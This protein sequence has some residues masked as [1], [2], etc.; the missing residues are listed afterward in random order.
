MMCRE[1]DNNALPDLVLLIHS[2][3]I[4]I[5]DKALFWVRMPLNM[6]IF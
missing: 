2:L 6:R 3:F 5:G 4:I 1:A